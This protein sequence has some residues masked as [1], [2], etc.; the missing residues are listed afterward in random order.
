MFTRPGQK[1]AAINWLRKKREMSI[2][3]SAGNEKD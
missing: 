3:S 2:V 1:L